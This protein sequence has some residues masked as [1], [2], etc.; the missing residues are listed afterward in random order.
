VQ[1]KSDLN[2]NKQVGAAVEFLIIDSI[3]SR[4]SEGGSKNMSNDV[5]KERKS[6]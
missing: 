4:S 2:C 3:V 5:T 1:G 6:D